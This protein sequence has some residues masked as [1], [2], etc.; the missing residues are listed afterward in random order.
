MVEGVEDQVVAMEARA[1]LEVIMVEAVLVAL[2]ML[3]DLLVDQVQ[4]VSYGQV[5]HD[6]SQVPV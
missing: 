6:N 2:G 1:V 3:L 5:Q 4:F